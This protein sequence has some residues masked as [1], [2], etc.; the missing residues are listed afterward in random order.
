MEWL[1]GKKTYIVAI[2]AGLL[3]AAQLIFPEFNV[4]EWGWMLL[5]AAGLGAIR[6]A[7]TKQ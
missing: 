1:K 5:S 4:P 7:I 3:T 2:A 6:A